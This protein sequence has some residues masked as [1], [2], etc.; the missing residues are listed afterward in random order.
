LCSRAC[1]WWCRK[2]ASLALLGANGAGKTTTLK[3][4]SNLLKAERGQVT[5]GSI[6]FKGERVDTH[7]RQ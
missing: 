2:A 6:T 1:R 3:A 7:D 5:K 4:V